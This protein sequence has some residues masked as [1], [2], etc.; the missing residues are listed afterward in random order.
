[1]NTP[2]NQTP[3]PLRVSTEEVRLPILTTWG[4]PVRKSRIQFQRAL[5][6]PRLLSLGMSLAGT[7]VLNAEL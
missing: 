4:L 6:S 2:R 7:I 3:H 5:L 1:M